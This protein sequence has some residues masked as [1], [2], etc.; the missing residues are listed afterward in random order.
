[1]P[2]PFTT[3]QLWEAWERVR[4]NQGCAGADGVTVHVFAQRAHRLI[5]DLEARVREGRYRPYPLLKI[6]VEK[7]PGSPATRTLLV[8]AVRDRVLQTAAARHLSRSFEE[9]FLECSYGYRPGRSVDRAIAR[10]RKCRELG[11]IFVMDGD[12]QSFFDRVDHSLLLARL[13]ERRPGEELMHLLRLWVSAH[14]W[15]GSHIRPLHLGVPQG[16]PI[17]PLLANFF[18]EDFDRELEKSGHKLIRYGDDFL[19]LAKTQGDAQAA[20]T[21]SEELL[22][23]AHLE[24]N[25]D[26]TQVVDFA[27][28][29][30]FLGAL[31]LGEAV[32]VPWKHER[33]KGRILFMAR[34]LPPSRRGAYE[35]APPRGTLEI[36]FEKAASTTVPPAPANPSPVRNPPVAFLYLTEQ[37]AVLRKAGDRF[38]VDKDDEVLL[39]LPYH[40]L[41]NVLLFGNVQVTTQALAELLEKGVNLSLFSRQGHYRGSL[42][43]PRGHNI[44]LRVKQFDAY[45]DSARSLALARAIVESKVANALSVLAHYREKHPVSAGFQ[46]LRAQIEAAMESCAAA[47]TVAALDGFEG[48]AARA[49]FTCVMEFNRSP[50]DWPG[51]QKH[52]STDPLNALL[53]LT[54]T[55]LMHEVTGLLEGAGLDPYLG[56]LHQV[57]QGRP[58]LALDLMEPFRH[59][60]ADR[61]VL[62]LINRGVIGAEDF[63]G[64]GER[65]GVFLAPTVM[66]RYLAEYE[67]WMLERPIAGGAGETRPRFRDLL[68]TEVEKMVAALREG[69]A[70]PP[71]RWQS[72]QSGGP[73]NTSSVTI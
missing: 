1:V 34:P 5:P 53:S 52:P 57:D 49:Y 8:P 14:V 29:F 24:L 58:S 23:A 64:G 54:Y 43:P 17:S 15:D 62:T 40:K 56:F 59:P 20:M 16:S 4:E 44:E 66:K 39:D 32:W 45:R 65:A 42:A 6:V 13:A 37:G 21:Q 27:H 48:S 26:K 55:L 19:I 2:L 22:A 11:Y 18:L 68:K 36:A 69:R 31:F 35:F 9:E 71:F 10:I 30:R 7:K 41:E 60:V 3:D 47:E 46:A 25:R 38:L 63:H 33:A 70:F 50:M 28:G 51:R 61:L 72:P 12:V 67:R 73:C